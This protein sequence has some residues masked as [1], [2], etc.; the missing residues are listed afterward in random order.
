M[1]APVITPIAPLADTVGVAPVLVLDVTIVDT[2]LGVDLATVCAQVVEVGGLAVEAGIV[3]GPWAGSV[4]AVPDGYRIQITRLFALDPFTA[5]TVQID[6]QDTVA[7]PSQLVWGFTTGELT[8]D[9]FLPKK[10]THREE[11]KSRL[12]SQF[13]DSPNLQGLLIELVDQVEGHA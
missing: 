4:D 7:T 13:S 11:A 9:P 10:T 8:S 1:A 5:Y 12:L 2:V 6:A 3:V